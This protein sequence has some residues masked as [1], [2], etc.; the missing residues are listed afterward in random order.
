MK[1]E[2]NKSNMDIEDQKQ[3]SSKRCHNMDPKHQKLLIGL[4]IFLAGSA[5]IIGIVVGTTGSTS[6]EMMEG[7]LCKFTLSM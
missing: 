4:V 2:N 6:S 1:S 3:D 5:L 7:M